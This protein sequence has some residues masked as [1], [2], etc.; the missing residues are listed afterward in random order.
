MLRIL[1][2]LMILVAIA[3]ESAGQPPAATAPPAPPAAAPSAEAAKADALPPRRPR[4]V[5]ATCAPMSPSDLRALAPARINAEGELVVRHDDNPLGDSLIPCVA[6]RKTADGK[7]SEEPR[8]ARSF[9]PIVSVRHE[10]YYLADVLWFDR[11]GK[12]VDAAAAR[13]QLAKW[14]PVLVLPAEKERCFPAPFGESLLECYRPDLL[15]AVTPPEAS[16]NF[17]YGPPLQ[18]PAPQSPLPI[19]A[20]MDE[21]GRVVFRPKR[22]HLVP[23]VRSKTITENTET[24]AKTK[25]VCSRILKP[26]IET[27]EELAVETKYVQFFDTEGNPVEAA[28]AA[29]R[30]AKEATVLVS[31]DGEKVN[32]FYLRAV[33]PGTLV[34][35][36]PFDILTARTVPAPLKKAPK[37]APVPAPAA[38]TPA[39][40]PT[41]TPAPAP[42]K[43]Q[44]M[45]APLPAPAPA[46]AP[47]MDPVDAPSPAQ[48]KEAPAPVKAPAKAPK[49]EAAP[50]PSAAPK[51]AP[52]PSPD[53]AA[54]SSSSGPS[55]ATERTARLAEWENLK[56]GMYLLAQTA[57]DTLP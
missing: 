29:Q 48:A 12:Q 18:G 42:A 9:K 41:P 50:L 55:P 16:L 6:L 13:A 14:T 44:E 30:L 34:C 37:A 38:P 52:P 51:V 11:N 8:A 33:K 22:I 46:P 49:E 23:E 4:Q 31:G 45:A 7:T 43:A 3:A 28:A 27:M 39:P 47:K 1:L 57:A 26:V 15:I 17:E 36:L 5:P 35:V 10:F 56:Y 24:G 25:E 19:R 20:N 2:S 40:A 32:A 54:G 21:K 53:T